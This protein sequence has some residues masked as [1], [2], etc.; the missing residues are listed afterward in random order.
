MGQ[1]SSTPPKPKF[2]SKMPLNRNLGVTYI[3]EAADVSDPYYWEYDCY[4]EGWG[5]V[6][7]LTVLLFFFFTEKICIIKEYWPLIGC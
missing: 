4:R 5:K 3:S 2:K 6:V 1:G 7:T